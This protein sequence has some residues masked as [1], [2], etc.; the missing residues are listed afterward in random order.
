MSHICNTT[1]QKQFAHM[2]HNENTIKKSKSKTEDELKDVKA[3]INKTKIQSETLKKIVNK[4][5]DKTNQS[6]ITQ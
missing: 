4:L 2:S 1:K 3:F 6:K 5:N